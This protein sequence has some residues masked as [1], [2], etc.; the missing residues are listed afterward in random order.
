MKC[1]FWLLLSKACFAS[2]PEIP[3]AFEPS[4]TPGTFVA[5]G[6][7]GAITLHQSGF[8]LATSNSRVEIHWVRAAH[9][10][11]EAQERLPGLA[12][13]FVGN[14]PAA[15]RI[16][17]PRYARVVF[18]GTYRGIDVVYYEKQAALECDFV[19]APLTDPA[20]IGFEVAGGRIATNGDLVIGGVRWKRPILL[21]GERRIPGGF[22]RHGRDRF[23]FKVGPYDHNRE[24]V[25]DP[26][27]IFSTYVGGSRN[28]L[29]RGLAVDSQGN[30]Y[31]AGITSSI[32]L[33]VKSALQ[34]AF[35]GSTAHPFTGDAFVAK[36]SPAGDV[37]YLTY[38]GGKGDDF[39]SAIAVDSDGNAYITGSTNST[40]FPVTKGA[41]Q[42]KFSGFANNDLARF[43]DVFVAKL[44]PAGDRLLYSTYFGGSHND[45]GLGIQVDAAG[46]VYVTG[47]TASAD[48]PTTAGAYQTKF[49]G[50]GGQ[51]NLPCCAAPA[52][53]AG[54][55]FI[56]KLDPMHS[57]IV[58][59]TFLGGTLDD[60]AFALALNEAGEAYVAGYTLS[61]NFPTTLGAFQRKFG[62][63]ESRTPDFHRGDGFLAKLN[64][65]G[66]TI[67][68]STYFGGEG[69]E[70]IA[71]IALDKS[72]AIYLTGAS[73]SAAG[74]PV[75][76]SAL[77]TH[78]AGYTKLPADIEILFGN[79]FVAKMN[80]T[81]SALEYCTF[82]G[83]SHNDSGLAVA[84]DG[85]GNAYIT[86]FTESPDFPVTHDA[87]QPKFGGTSSQ[88]PYVLFG[89]AFFSIINVDGTRLLYST[90]LGGRGDDIGWNVAM[91]PSGNVY[92]TGGTASAD[93][94]VKGQA[95]QGTFGGFQETLYFFRGDAFLSKFS[96]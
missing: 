12:N 61:R 39:A 56:F 93:F 51:D 64:A 19:I 87:A 78:Y 40:D 77:Q 72:G 96:R 79:A 45:V 54:D 16:R 81:G 82:L 92:V 95:F 22:V 13:S 24:L 4:A 59:S 10:S 48:F 26:G 85:G 53:E 35:A 55:A 28:E 3:F 71:G 1:V 65:D 60:G 32:D 67:A 8:S 47:A 11:V 75:T 31:I 25:I 7:P 91:D 9:P 17:S 49:G 58:Y 88:E 44:N 2:A 5:R 43:G 30:V 6:L 84:V 36:F 50:Q 38:L 20:R 23:G 42:T 34:S 86:G 94:P 80:P 27:L 62:G 29:A 76:P 57:K 41:V 52:F 68:F 63:V 37:L 69:D 90:F 15:W 21:Q 46:G 66:T 14:D 33:P 83:G 70:W 18:R 89:D 74:F 73:S